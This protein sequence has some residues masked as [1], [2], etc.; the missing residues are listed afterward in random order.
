SLGAGLV[1]AYCS[2]NE[3][4]VLVLVF[5]KVGFEVR[6]VE[7]QFW[8][9]FCCVDAGVVLLGYWLL[10]L[11]EHVGIATSH[12]QQFCQ[13]LVLVCFSFNVK[14]MLVVVCAKL[15]S[16]L[17]QLCCSFGGFRC[18]DAGLVLVVAGFAIVACGHGD[19][20]NFD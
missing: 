14:V 6:S 17:D 1:L 2:F 19:P 3:I 13:G 15:G 12:A 4:V 5:C 7:L 16:G 20:T 8:L 10:L 11:S 18:E 9:V